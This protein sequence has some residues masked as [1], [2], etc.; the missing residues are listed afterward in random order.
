MGFKGHNG[1]HCHFVFL[2]EKQSIVAKSSSEAELIALNSV[3]D[4]VEWLLQL[5]EA[6]GPAFY[7]GNTVKIEQ[8]NTSTIQIAN[9]GRGSFKRS[10]HINVRY[11]WIKRLIDLGRV[12]LGYVSTEFILSD[13][14]T[15]PCA[16]PRFIYLLRRILGWT[17]MPDGGPWQDIKEDVGADVETD[18]T[19]A[20]ADQDS[21]NLPQDLRG[22]SKNMPKSITKT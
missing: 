7:T 6:M 2:S 8:D 15:K 16:R 21:S 22:V 9:A 18:I 5:L 17:Q 3:G 19:T 20:K 14:L 13:L 10:K 4:H 11:Y 12:L 1:E